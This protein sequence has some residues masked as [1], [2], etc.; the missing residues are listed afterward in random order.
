VPDLFQQIRREHL[1]LSDIW[2]QH[3]E[4][5]IVVSRLLTLVLGLRTPYNPVTFM[6]LTALCLMASACAI[7]A[8]CRLQYGVNAPIVF[9]PLAFLIFSLRQ[10][11]NLL[12][13]FSDWLRLGCVP[14]CGRVLVAFSDYTRPTVEIR[15]SDRCRHVSDLLVGPRLAGVACG[16][17]YAGAGTNRGKNPYRSP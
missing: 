12:W 4:H 9:V 11:G 17:G 3:N 2:Q 10:F 15:R 16:T 7:F 5:R 6:Y 1:T 8:A 13:D 14:A